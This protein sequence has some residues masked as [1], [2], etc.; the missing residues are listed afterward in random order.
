MIEHIPALL[1]A[2]IT[3][4]KIEGRAKAAYYVAVAVN[5]YRAALDAATQGKTVP[6]W[7]LREPYKLSHRAYCT[8][9]FFDRPNEAAQVNLAGGYMRP[10]EVI[11]IVERWQDGICCAKQRGRAFAGD[12]LEALIPGREPVTLVLKEL[13]DA[14]GISIDATRHP[15]MRF[16]FSCKTELPMGAMLRKET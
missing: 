14:D 5:A 15:E 3:S 12:K 2:G 13:R 4:L 16:M 1:D 9:F 6:V 10:W 7:A 11:G 8:G